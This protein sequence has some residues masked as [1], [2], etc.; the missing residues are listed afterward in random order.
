M[1]EEKVTP[2]MTRWMFLKNSTAVMTGLCFAFADIA[3]KVFPQKVRRRPVIRPLSVHPRNPRY[4]AGD[5]GRVDYLTGFQFWDSLHE[6]GTPNLDVLNFDQ[7]LDIV[8]RYS[9]NFMRLWRWNELSKY[10]H[11]GS[12]CS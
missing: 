1:Y 5:G 7:F 8:E 4:F 9:A 12:L 10:R 11:S 2:M 3:G 6:N